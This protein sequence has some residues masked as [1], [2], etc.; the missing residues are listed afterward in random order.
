MENSNKNIGLI[1]DLNLIINE[2][3]YEVKRAKLITIL[4]ALGLGGLIGLIV[5]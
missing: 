1:N 5:V 2:K 3:S 4:T